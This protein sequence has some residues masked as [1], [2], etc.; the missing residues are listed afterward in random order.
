MRSVRFKPEIRQRLL[1][2][3]LK[4]AEFEGAV[5]EIADEADVSIG[6]VKRWLDALLRE[7]AEEELER[8]AGE[9]LERREPG[10]LLGAAS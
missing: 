3:M 5:A 8:L 2:A 9:E 6:T 4:Q 1:E 7:L 10:K